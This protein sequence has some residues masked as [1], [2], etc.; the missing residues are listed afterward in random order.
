VGLM[1]AA[2]WGRLST[3]HCPRC[4]STMRWLEAATTREAAAR[5]LGKL[6]LAPLPPTAPR[7][8]PWGFLEC[9]RITPARRGASARGARYASRNRH[10][11]VHLCRTK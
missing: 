1:A 4:D 8:A 3:E 11:P 6:G 2:D 5:L 7:G 10:S 9:R